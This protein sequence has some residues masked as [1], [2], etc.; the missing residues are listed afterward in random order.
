MVQRDDEGIR[1]LQALENNL[2]QLLSQKQQFQGQLFEIV[3]A[4]EELE[5]TTE[6]YKIL[7][8]ILLK[9]DPA[10]L[11]KELDEKKELFEIRIQSIEKQERSTKEQA[12]ELQQQVLKTMEK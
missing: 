3:S 5:T 7:G 2:Q 4:I 12:K 10:E 6:S 8:G 9:K 1:Q 11:K